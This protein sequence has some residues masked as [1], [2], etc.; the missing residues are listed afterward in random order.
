MSV[1]TVQ[2]DTSSAP[3]DTGTALR[4]FRVKVP[5][6]DLAEL[7][8]RINAARLPEKG[9]RRRLLAAGAARHG[10][11]AREVLVRP[12]HERAQRA[13]HAHGAG[14]RGPARARVGGTGGA[15]PPG[16]T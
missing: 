2:A 12:R 15:K 13:S 6:A 8:K 1:E 9:N 16:Q 14:R 11:E 10:P 4:P 5:E 7:R 3:P